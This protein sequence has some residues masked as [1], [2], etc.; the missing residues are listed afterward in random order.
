MIKLTFSWYFSLTWFSD[1][2]KML[3]PILLLESKSKSRKFISFFKSQHYGIIDICKSWSAINC[4]DTN[5]LRKCNILIENMWEGRKNE[6][7]NA[8]KKWFY[9][10]FSKKWLKK[11]KINFDVAKNRKILWFLNIFMF[12]FVFGVRWQ[13]TKD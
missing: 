3:S 11:H 9:F 5:E 7:H 12:C 2:E 13:V 1:K 10:Y 6:F 8:D 4:I